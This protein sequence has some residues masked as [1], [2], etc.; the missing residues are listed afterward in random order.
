PRPKPPIQ[1]L[2]E[3]VRAATEPILNPASRQPLIFNF[4]NTS[5]KAILDVIANATGINITYDRE[6]VDR[7]GI[8]LQLNGVTLEEALNQI[9]TTNGPAYK[10][11]NDRPIL[12]SPDTSPK[13]RRDEDEMTKALYL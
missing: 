12:V 2:R 1:E 13:H 6:V 10:I 11:V 7:A 5:I 3:R 9:L 8:S 4:N